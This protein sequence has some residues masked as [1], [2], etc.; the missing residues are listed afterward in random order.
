MSNGEMMGGEATGEPEQRAYVAPTPP[1]SNPNPVMNAFR[2]KGYD[3]SS[4]ESDDQ[5]VQTIESGLSQLNQI[6]ELRN[7]LEAAQSV[8]QPTCEPEEFETTPE[9]VQ[10]YPDPWSPPEFDDRWTEMLSVDDSGKYVPANEHINPS[11]AIK[12]NEYRDWMRSKG[13]EFWNNPYEFM[14]PGLEGWVRDMVDMQ[15]GAAIEQQA[16]DTNVNSFLQSN[17][18]RFYIT[19]MNGNPLSDPNTGQEMLTPQGEMLKHHATEARNLGISDTQSI[20][21]YAL[22]MLERDLYASQ[23]NQQY[24]AQQQPQQQTFLQEAA[25]GQ[26]YYAPNREATVRSA[27]EAGRAQND[28]MSFFDMALPELVNMGLVQQTG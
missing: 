23:Q 3:T 27:A 10:E 15:V 24:Y 22:N 4:F 16:S 28:G 1:D 6:P 13:K 7:Q 21:E 19:D 5:F 18:Q 25:Q 11:V 12:A 26:E 14:K 17:A 8:P 20:Q 2:S 9:P